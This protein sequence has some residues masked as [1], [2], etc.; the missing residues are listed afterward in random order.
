MYSKIAVW[1]DAWVGQMARGA[2]ATYVRVGL[3]EVA[4][5]L[6]VLTGEPHPLTISSPGEEYPPDEETMTADLTR[7]HCWIP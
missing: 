6:P 5:T 3:P 2:M 1:A 7:N 4:T